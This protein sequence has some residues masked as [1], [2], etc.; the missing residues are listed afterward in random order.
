MSIIKR[1]I[2]AWLTP[3]ACRCGDHVVRRIDVA[4]RIGASDW[5]AWRQFRRT[6]HVAIHATPDVE[7]LSKLVHEPERLCAVPVASATVSA[8]EPIELPTELG[9]QSASGPVESVALLERTRNF[10]RWPPRGNRL[11]W[12]VHELLSLLSRP[13]LSSNKAE[14]TC[15]VASLSRAEFCLPGIRHSFSSGLTTGENRARYSMAFVW[16]CV[17]HIARSVTRRLSGPLSTLVLRS[18]AVPESSP[19]AKAALRMNQLCTR[20]ALRAPSIPPALPHPTARITSRLCKLVL[21][22]YPCRPSAGRPL[23]PKSSKPCAAFW[24]RIL[25]VS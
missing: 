16:S 4:D 15:V 17:E 24:L 25:Q 18:C 7:S 12:R 21:P 14:R 13:S 23:N 2:G 11:R 22:S 20:S 8:T 3:N 6:F 5:R 10:R 9:H 1:S 19:A